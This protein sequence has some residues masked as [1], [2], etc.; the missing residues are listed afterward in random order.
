MWSRLQEKQYRQ[1]GSENQKLGFCCGHLKFEVP[2][3]PPSGGVKL[4]DKILW[5]LEQEINIGVIGV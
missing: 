2:G 4:L 1:V 5:N 3:M